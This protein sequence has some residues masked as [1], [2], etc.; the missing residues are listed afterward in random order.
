MPNDCG[1]PERLHELFGLF[2]Q[3]LQ[4]GTELHPGRSATVAPQWIDANDVRVRSHAV[5]LSRWW[6]VFN[7]PVLNDLIEHAYNQNINLKEFGTRILQARA[8]LAITRGEL[9][10]QTQ[11][12]TGSYARTA[13]SAD[14]L[15]PGLNKFNDQY[16]MGFNLAWELDFWGQFRR[17]VLGANAQLDASVENYDAVLVTLLGDVATNYVQ[18]RQFQE[19]IELARH[20]VKLQND[21]LGIVQA[22]FRAGS[23]NELDVDQAQSTLSQTESAIPGFKILLRQAQD[24]LCTLLGIPP[25]DLEAR[26]GQRPI[27]TAP[28]DVAVGI[29]AELLMRRPDVRAAERAA[30]AQAQQ[31]GIAQ[32]ALYPH[33]SITGTLGYS[34]LQASQLFTNPSFQGSVGPTFT[35]NIL[36]YG[37]IQ[38]NVRMQDALFQQTL[39]DYRTTVL[40]ANQQAEDGLIT[41]LKAQERTK[42]LTESVVAANLAYEIVTQQYRVGTVDFNR[43]DVIAQNL[44]QQQDLEAQARSQIATGLIQVYRA[45]GGG[46]Q[47]R[48]G[49]ATDG[50]RIAATNS[51]HAPSQLRSSRKLRCLRRQLPNGTRDTNVLLS[52][53][54]TWKSGFLRRARTQAEEAVTQK[55]KGK[56]EA[57]KLGKGNPKSE[58]GA[59]TKTGSGILGPKPLVLNIGP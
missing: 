9:F 55:A 16:N 12:A 50:V 31:I 33:I 29:P 18:M 42:Y 20:N 2:P 10:P 25:C 35:W 6:C 39:L 4:G 36:N 5:D 22:R 56:G 43:V 26:L 52:S 54:G 38:N 32:A 3:R 11:T 7:D 45:L 41:F 46:W 47:I 48:L 23:A 58:K 28:V 8:Q 1:L 51:G 40:T 59:N 14:Q 13:T 34:A 19:Q 30:A 53:I 17:Q 44:V 27:P 15:L 21:I 24:R 37:R 49:S 57:R